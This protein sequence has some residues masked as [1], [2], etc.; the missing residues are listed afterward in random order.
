LWLAGFHSFLIHTVAF[1]AN[2]RII[3]F[4]TPTGS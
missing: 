2:Q 3:Y 1:D 4:G